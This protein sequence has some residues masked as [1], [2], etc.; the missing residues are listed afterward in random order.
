MTSLFSTVLGVFGYIILGFIFNKTN[1]I[2]SK[3]LKKFNF[4]SFNILLPIA[5]ISNFWKIKFPEILLIQLLLDFFGAGLIIFLIGF[6]FSNKF[7]HFKTDDSA[8][9]GLGGCFGNS[10]AL[11]IPL[12]YSI[13]GPKDAMPYMVL[14]LFHGF[15]HFT[16][17]NFFWYCS[18][19]NNIT[20]EVYLI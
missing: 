7:F 15:I 5:L 19:E 20:L 14:V 10:V 11:L 12:M 8:L 1:F 13:L 4:I 18:L 16:Y 2:T 9:F 17:T 3:F 6:F